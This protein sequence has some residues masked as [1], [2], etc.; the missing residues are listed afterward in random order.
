MR[1]I[2]IQNGQ[3][4]GSGCMIKVGFPECSLFGGKSTLQKCTGTWDRGGL[5]SEVANVLWVWD[6]QSVTRTLS[7]LGSVSAFRT[8]RSGRFDCNYD[9]RWC[10][11]ICSWKFHICSC[12][13][14]KY[15][16]KKH[17]NVASGTAMCS[18][19]CMLGDLTLLNG[20]RSSNFLYIRVHK[21]WAHFIPKV[22]LLH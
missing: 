11:Y 10:L 5:F 9:G 3:N 16:K 14:A 13:L 20:K 8:V 1:L 4:W 2:G 18:Q 6:F 12:K 7:A 19:Q 15:C 22:W 17:V 21:A